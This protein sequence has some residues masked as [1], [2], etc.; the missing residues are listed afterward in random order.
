MGKLIFYVANKGRMYPDKRL[1][2]LGSLP[3]LFVFK[4]LS[5]SYKYPNNNMNMQALDT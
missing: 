1:N 4:G 3:V 5:L 2:G